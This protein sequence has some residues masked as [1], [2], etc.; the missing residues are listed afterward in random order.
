MDD[1]GALVFVNSVM[2]SS[3]LIRIVQVLWMPTILAVPL[4]TWDG[5]LKTGR[6]GDFSGI[7]QKAVAA[8]QVSLTS[9]TRMPICS[10]IERAI[11]VTTAMMIGAG[12]LLVAGWNL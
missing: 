5:E 11:H 3:V 12:A 9:F 10:H 2:L 4:R 7:T 1:L 8:A 6:F